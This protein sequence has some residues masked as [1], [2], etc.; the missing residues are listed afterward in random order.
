MNSPRSRRSIAF[1]L[2]YL[3]FA[4][5]SL[6]LAAAEIVLGAMG[7]VL[8]GPA[9]FAVALARRPP[10]GWR[11]VDESLDIEKVLEQRVEKRDKR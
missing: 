2:G 10:R 8:I 6:L 11:F 5:S 9:A 7:L 3:L 1:Q 4:L